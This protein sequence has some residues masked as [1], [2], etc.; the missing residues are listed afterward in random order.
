LVILTFLDS[1]PALVR[2][3]TDQI[4]LNKISIAPVSANTGVF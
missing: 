4:G 3:V 1:L 2:L